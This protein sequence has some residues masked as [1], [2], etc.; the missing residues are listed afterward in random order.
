[1]A[2]E[3]VDHMSAEQ[4]EAARKRFEGIERLTAGD[5]ADSIEYIVTRPRHVAVNEIMIRPAQQDW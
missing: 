2:T 5:I 1:M 3:L 4:Q